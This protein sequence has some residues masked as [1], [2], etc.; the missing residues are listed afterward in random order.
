LSLTN[1]GPASKANL[2]RQRAHPMLSVM[3]E[4]FMAGSVLMTQP[5]VQRMMSRFCLDT[6]HFL[7]SWSDATPYSQDKDR[8]GAGWVS[9][10]DGHA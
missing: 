10:C 9:A 2:V 6:I 7:T 8:P 1:T 4:F 3:E 5:Q